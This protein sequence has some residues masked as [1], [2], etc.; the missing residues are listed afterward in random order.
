MR[1]D[2]SCGIVPV[3]RGKEDE[4]LILKHTAGHWGFP[5]GHKE[6]EETEKETALRELREETGIEKCRIVDSPLIY[7]EYNFTDKDEEY[8]KIVK[9]LVGF[10][11]SKFVRLPE[12]EIVAY[13]WA[14]Y[15]KAREILSYDNNRGVLE[16]AREICDKINR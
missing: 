16:E 5:K 7:E 2:R 8:H 15:K 14:S 11:D 3:W 12:H 9:Y 10:V 13:E 4:F 1:E 6:G